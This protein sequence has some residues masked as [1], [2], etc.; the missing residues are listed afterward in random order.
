MICRVT[1]NEIT[2]NAVKNAIKAPRAIDED[3]VNAQQYKKNMDR[4]VEFIRCPL[5][6]EKR[7]E[8]VLAQAACNL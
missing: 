8:R 7:L 6:L 3:L 5:S 2:K 4:I 1:F